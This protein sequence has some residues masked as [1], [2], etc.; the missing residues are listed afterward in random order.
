MIF[1]P[2]GV[3]YFQVG[4]CHHMKAFKHANSM[5]FR[6]DPLP[7]QHVSKLLQASQILVVKLFM[8]RMMLQGIPNNASD[9]QAG[10]FPSNNRMF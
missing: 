5:C 8:S 9:Q 4:V 7:M 1:Y 6:R 3:P 10:F 2:E